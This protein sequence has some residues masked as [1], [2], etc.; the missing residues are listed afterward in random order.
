MTLALSLPNQY[1]AALKTQIVTIVLP[2]LFIAL[3]L[4]TRIVIV[5]SPGWDD[6]ILTMG[7]PHSWSWHASIRYF[8]NLLNG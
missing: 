4:Y 7:M 5:K 3:R 8:A 6:Y 2:I 1:V